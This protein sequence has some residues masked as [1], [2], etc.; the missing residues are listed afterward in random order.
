MNATARLDLYLESFRKRLR[1]LSLLQG[2]AITAL[3]L[4][5]VATAGAWFAVESGFS[6]TT[7]NAFR[8]LLVLALA[9]AVLLALVD[10][11]RRLRER[12]AGD[13]ERRVPAFDGRITTYAQLRQE[14]NPFTDLLAEDALRISE[15]HPIATQVPQAELNKAGIVLGA[16]LVVLLYLL[17]SGPG[18]LNFSLRNLLAGWAVDGLLPPQSIAVVPGDQSVRRGANLR[19]TSTMSGFDPDNATMHIRGADGNWQEVAMVQSPLGFEFTFFSL[20]NN[21]QYYISA[22]GIRSPEFG[23]NVVDVPGIQSL[24]LTYNFP[25]WTEREPETASGG[26]VRAL[27]ETGID[28]VATTTAPLAGGALVLN[29]AAQTMTLNGNEASTSFQVLQEG[30]YYIAALVGGEQVRI[31]DDFF[32]R[33]TEDGKPEIEVQRPG[34]DY[35]AS[36]IEEVLTRVK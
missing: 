21:M 1:T 23:I 31:S 35:N 30:Q 27:P 13:V 17:I 14:Q 22:S 2:A 26:D 25:E 7:I 34:G 16:T 15:Q 5:V 19:I 10:P 11:L 29:D 3:V 20:Q 9:S 12:L 18:L 6:S 33:L 8:V 36:G 32:I 4:L 24:S 28:L